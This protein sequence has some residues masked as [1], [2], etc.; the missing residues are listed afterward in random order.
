MEPSE[1]RRQRDERMG[2]LE[3]RLAKGYR[4][5]VRTPVALL[6]L[7]VCF[8]FLWTLRGELAYQ[9]SSKEPLTLGSEGDYHWDLLASNR[10][11]Q[12]HGV[13]T[14]R[15]VYVQGGH[16]TR[17]AVGLQQTPV[18]VLRSLVSGE[19]LT[20]H[21]SPPPPNSQ[22]MAVRGRLLREDAA[23]EYAQ[24]L[25]QFGSTEHLPAVQGARWLLVQGPAPGRDSSAFLVATLLSL[26][27]LG[28]AWVF[29]RGLLVKR[30]VD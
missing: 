30:R 23:G 9:F 26:F 8:Y 22:P 29:A 2:E 17:M 15:G 21:G 7:G 6:A 24:V 28:N 20:S 19:E 14:G 27:A 1:L 12:I 5:T 25:K 18:L 16:E 11:A 3:S 13:P 4:I 10:Y